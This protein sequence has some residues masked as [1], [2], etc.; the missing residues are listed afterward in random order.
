M[1]LCLYPEGRFPE[2]YFPE[3]VQTRGKASTLIPTR[4]SMSQVSPAFYTIVT[5]SWSQ[6]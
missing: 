4:A 5:V 2:Y 3:N 1:A 6:R